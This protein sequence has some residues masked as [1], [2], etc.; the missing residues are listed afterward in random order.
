M[1]VIG[2]GR[3]LTG[4]W[5]P[6]PLHHGIGHPSVAIPTVH[7]TLEG[8]PRL[9]LHRHTVRELATLL[10]DV[11]PQFHFQCVIAPPSCVT[12]RGVL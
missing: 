6:T 5:N 7:N 2:A 10:R 3:C 12:E 8:W 4:R 1:A 9:D 11:V